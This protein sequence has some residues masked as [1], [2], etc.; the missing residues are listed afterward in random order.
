MASTSIEIYTGSAKGFD[1]IKV[2][3]LNLFDTHVTCYQIGNEGEKLSIPT[4]SIR[5]IRE[6]NKG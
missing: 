3:K 4:T 1:T 6:T 5:M 2:A